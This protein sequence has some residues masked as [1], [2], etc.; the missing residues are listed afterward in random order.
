TGTNACAQIASATSQGANS[1]LDELRS[2]A[3]SAD[4]KSLYVT[5]A[6]DDAVARFDR[7]PAT[8]A[9]SYQGCFTGETETGP[10]GT[11]A[12]AQIGSATSAGTDSGL[13]FLQSV[14]V[15]ADGKSVY[16]GALL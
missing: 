2:L 5:A 1:G 12:C 14:A 15:S 3:L 13:D 10:T 16:A 8:G 7:D 4:G 9:L 11:A 6:A